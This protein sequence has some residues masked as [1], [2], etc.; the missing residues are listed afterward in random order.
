MVFIP[1]ESGIISNLSHSCSC[2][3][4]GYGANGEYYA[5]PLGSS[6]HIWEDTPWMRSTVCPAIASG[7]DRVYGAHG[8]RYWGGGSGMNYPFGMGIDYYVNLGRAIHNPTI[9]AS[10]QLRTGDPARDRGQYMMIG[11]TPPGGVPVI[12]SIAENISSDPPEYRQFS[13]YIPGWV[14][15]YFVMVFNHYTTPS[16]SYF[17]GVRAIYLSD[18][19]ANYDNYRHFLYDDT[20]AWDSGSWAG[21]HVKLTSGGS[22]GLTSLILTNTEKRLFLED[23]SILNNVEPGDAYIIIG[24]GVDPEVVRRRRASWVSGARVLL[25][26]SMSGEMRG[27]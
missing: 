3:F 13:K 16:Y 18:V 19:S 17:E 9:K 11:Y 20:K 22:E 26:G 15:S 5:G 21:Y 1:V 24:M 14:E 10:V 7:S 4:P 6:M 12:A 27:I 25:P 2:D 8:R 23:E